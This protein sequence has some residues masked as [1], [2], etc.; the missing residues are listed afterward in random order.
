MITCQW[1]ITVLILEMFKLV[2][3][4]CSVQLRSATEMK[5]SSTFQCHLLLWNWNLSFPFAVFS[6]YQRMCNRDIESSICREMSGDLEMG[7][8]AVG[9][10][11]LG[12]VISAVPVQLPR[13]GPLTSAKGALI[14]GNSS[15]LLFMLSF[16][17]S[18]LGFVKWGT[19]PQNDRWSFFISGNCGI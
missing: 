18:H 17:W 11:S 9:M 19:S 1:L 15:F 13:V 5:P 10:C 7:M 6:E 4:H 14:S 12:K 8:L 16:F 2:W 3:V